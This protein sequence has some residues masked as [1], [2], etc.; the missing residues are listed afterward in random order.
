MIIIT[1]KKAKE[2]QTRVNINTSFGWKSVTDKIAMTNAEQFKELYTEQLT[3]EEN[4]LFDF[5]NWNADTNWQ[6]EIFQIR[7]YYQ[8]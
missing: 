6:D 3:N 2:G 5:S 7:I 8:Q 4:P 1:T